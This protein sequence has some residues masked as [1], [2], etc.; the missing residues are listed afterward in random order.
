MDEAFHAR[1]S[2]ISP[3]PLPDSGTPG[4][5]QSPLA[6]RA[7]W[8]HRPLNS[9]TM[10]LAGQALVGPM[11]S[12]YRALGLPGEEP[13][14]TLHSLD[15][16]RRGDLI[17]IGVHANAFLHHMIRNIAGVLLAIGRARTSGGVGWRGP[18][19]AGSHARRRDGA[20]GRPFERVW[21]P[22]RVF[23]SG[24]GG[25]FPLFA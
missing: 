16:V 20:A 24:A 7:T 11:T 14:R 1:F 5:Q 13:V 6:G 23:D 22:G 4:A 8:S 3:L 18:G 9:D 19:A 10:H 12:S 21:Y 15:V 2:A 25:D 17:E